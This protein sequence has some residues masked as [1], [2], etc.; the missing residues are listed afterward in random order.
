MNGRNRRKCARQGRTTG[1]CTLVGATEHE[2]L[3]V[4]RLTTPAKPLRAVIV[5]VEVPAAPN[6]HVD[7]SWACSDSEVL[8][9]VGDCYGVG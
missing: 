3:L 4:V 2:V 8:N 6:V 9:N 1:A 5:T 7:T